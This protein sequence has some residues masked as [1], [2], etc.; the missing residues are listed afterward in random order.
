MTTE[1]GSVDEPRRVRLVDLFVRPPFAKCDACGAHALGRLTVTGDQLIRKCKECLHIRKTNLPPTRKSVIYLDQFAVSNMMKSLN[2]AT[3]SHGKLALKPWSELY[4]RAARLVQMQL[5]VCP[6]SGFHRLE[7]RLEPTLGPAIQQVISYLSGRARFPDPEYILEKRSI[8]STA[9]DEMKHVFRSWQREPLPFRE[10]FSIEIEAH[11]RTQVE[12]YERRLFAP[13]RLPYSNSLLDTIRK[14]RP[15]PR[16]RPSCSTSFDPK[17]SSTFRFFGF[18]PACTRPS[19]CAR[20]ARNIPRIGLPDR[21]RD[22]R[23]RPALLRR[24]HD[25]SGHVLSAERAQG[26]AHARGLGRSSVP[27]AAD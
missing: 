12:L 4:E 16:P 7:S 13:R 22:R 3:N 2:P 26:T 24:D 27:A 1:D 8:R 14:Q 11:R 5:V 18:R 6:E 20:K 10:R 21:R 23:Y 19:R 15:A 9:E 25:R 17:R